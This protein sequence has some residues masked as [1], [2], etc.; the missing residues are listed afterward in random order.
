MSVESI[1][2][3]LRCGRPGCPCA[4][5]G[6]LVHCPA[7]QDQRP[8]LSIEEKDG[9][10]LVRCFAGCD[11]HAVIDAL[12]ARGLWPAS[13]NRA[14]PRHGGRIV[15]RYEIRDPDGRLVAVHVREDGPG[16]KSFRWEGPDG[17]RGLD[18]LRVTELPLYAVERLG[19]SDRVILVEGEKAANALLRLGFPVVGTVTGASAVPCDASLEPLLGRV[20]FLWPDADP[21]GL[22][23]MQKIAHRLHA[24]GHPDIRWVTWQGA[25]PGGD[26]A[27]L[28]ASGAT[29]EDVERLLERAAAWRPPEAPD[30]AELLRNLEG[31]LRK[32]VVL[33]EGAA[34]AIS[35]WIL[36]TH[37]VD[38]FVVTPYLLITSPE[39]RCGKTLLL[40]LLREVVARPLVA[41]NIS[42][43]A[44]F[45]AVDAERCTLLLDEAQGL[46]DRSERSAALHDLL[47]AGHRRGQ[48]AIR[49]V[50]KGAEM[51]PQRFD[52]FGAKAVSLIGRP[53]DVL[54]DR[55][56]EVR[57]KRRAPHEQV[58]RFRIAR[59][60]EEGQDLRARIEAWVEAHREDVARAY[61]TAEPPKALN[62]RVRD[63]WSAL[64]AVVA[65]AD[66]SRLPEL[67]QAAL[68]LS[69]EGVPV[70]EESLGVRLLADI[71]RTFM[72]AGVDRLPTEGL[73]GALAEIEEAP[74][75]DF[76][77]RRITP[78]AL[79][80]L[81][82]PFGVRPERWR[83]GDRVIRGYILG[84]FGDAFAR[85]LPSGTLEP[86]QP[87]QTGNGAGSSHLGE[88]SQTPLVTDAQ[89]GRKPHGYGLVTDVTD[90]TLEIGGTKEICEGSPCPPSDQAASLTEERYLLLEREAIREEATLSPWEV[91]EALRAV[92]RA[93]AWEETRGGPGTLKEPKALPDPAPPPGPPGPEDLDKA[94]EAFGAH[95]ETCPKCSWTGGPRC[96]EGHRLQ[97]AYH[98]VWQQALRAGTLTHLPADLAQSPAQHEADG[99]APPEEGLPDWWLDGSLADLD[100]LER[101]LD[102]PGGPE[103]EPPDWPD[104]WPEGKDWL[105]A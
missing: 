23:H 69:G 26:A 86:S 57:M 21:P 49:M 16:G 52:V 78:Q 97:R 31:W 9:R 74:W 94:M 82:R 33:P 56:I 73:L 19:A 68:R 76:H 85:Y 67:E 20:A 29:R 5:P 59:V 48:A 92:E 104:V 79:A 99:P 38:V 98:Q 13:N 72:E 50:G 12:R 32:Y 41:A 30:G 84:A 17:R 63:N 25:P 7:H 88:P 27:D 15:T 18:G 11:Q 46:R 54:L 103:E 70:E 39:R 22:A 93:A 87:S 65:V 8:S 81:L 6:R 42:E 10:V 40:D 105:A 3:A 43:A 28:V 51:R 96:E 1:R 102:D 66:P 101:F 53:T 75:G 83:E 2:A 34:L 62:D 71:R 100:D 14:R 37:L 60:Q 58:E 91:E 61:E 95:V 4:R 47:C 24:L 45:R 55:G 35:A 90:S 77:G 89:N 44:L 36:H 64:F 80:R